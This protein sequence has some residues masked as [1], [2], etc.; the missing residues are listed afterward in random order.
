MYIFAYFHEKSMKMYDLTWFSEILHDFTCILYVFYMI[1]YE[2]TL[3]PGNW[4]PEPCFNQQ[5][6]GLDGWWSYDGREVARISGAVLIWQDGERTELQ[7]EEDRGRH[8]TKV[9]MVWQG[10]SYMAS[11]K[12]PGMAIPRLKWQRV[13]EEPAVQRQH[14]LHGQ[15]WT[16]FSFLIWQD[17][18]LGGAA[19]VYA[20][21]SLRTTIW[22]SKCVAQCLRKAWDP[23][24][25]QHYM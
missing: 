21:L 14:E 25:G 12:D 16:Q 11:V 6:P 19:S 2:K 10:M 3:Y 23:A 24:F 15:V 17:F 9:C 22:R 13:V 5:Q 20:L 1:L 8:E 18:G 7:V 4:H